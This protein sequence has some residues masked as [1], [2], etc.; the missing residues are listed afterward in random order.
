MKIAVSITTINV[1][2]L[3]D[4]LEDNRR[5]F[6]HDA[7]NILY[8]IT[9][10]MK[11]VPGARKFCYSRKQKGVNVVYLGVEE[12]KQFMGMYSEELARNFPLNCIPRRIFGDFYAYK[13]DV[14]I[15]VR[16]DDD[17]YPL[18]GI[19]FFGQH[20]MVSRNIRELPSVIDNEHGWYNYMRE[21]R[22]NAGSV[23]VFPRGYPYGMRLK[24][25]GFTTRKAMGRIMC[26]QGLWAGDP[27]IDAITRLAVP[28]QTKYDVAFAQE[29]ILNK[30][31]WAPINTQNTAIAAELL[32]A[33]FVFPNVGRFDDILGG[34]FQR[35]AMDLMGDYVRYGLPYVLQ[36][37]NIHNLG[38]DLENEIAGIKYID[39]IC[40]VLRSIV[41]ESSW[42]TYTDVACG[43]QE[44]MEILL[45]EQYPEIYR[46]I[47]SGLTFCRHWVNLFKG[48]GHRGEA[49]SA[50]GDEKSVP[51]FPK[52]LGCGMGA[53]PRQ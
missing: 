8:V 51:S 35:R 7:K 49:R 22:H 43:I 14:D 32:P 25:V 16:L 3:L 39:S 36:E 19:D 13:R 29:I 21:M 10:D 30:N 46:W 38:K 9:G 34:Y 2:V 23:E 44:Q 47:A 26:N 52:S 28:V 53:K 50:A 12:Q 15:I 11:T 37:R 31:V 6:N 40:A 27:D 5:K 41:R 18:P 17:N 33:S 1:P 45:R 24:N 20:M 4:A 42:S 48:A